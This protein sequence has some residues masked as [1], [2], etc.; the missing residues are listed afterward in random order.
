[1]HNNN[2]YTSK[3]IH[4]LKQIRQA[5]KASNQSMQKEQIYAD[6]PY[7]D[8]INE[9]ISNY[10]EFYTYYTLKLQ[11]AKVTRPALI[12]DIDPDLYISSEDATNLELMLKGKSPYA[13][14]EE[15]GQIELHHI[16]QNYNAPFAE[17]TQ[18]EHIMYGNNKVFHTASEESWRKDKILEK[19]FDKERSEYWRKRASGDYTAISNIDFIDIENKNFVL[20][21]ELQEEINETIEA[22]YNECSVKDLDYL[23]DLAKS[24]SLV[25]RTGFT[26]MSEFIFSTRNKDENMV[27][28]PN[29]KSSQ[30]TFYGF[31][32]NKYEKIQRYKCSWCGKTFTATSL[33]LISNTYFSYMDWIKFIDCIYNGYTLAQT[34]KAC[35]VSQQTVHSNKIKLFYALKIL[36]DQVQLKGNVVVDETYIPLSF[37]G[38]RTKNENFEMPREAHKRGG[39]IHSKGL[40]KDHV[41]IVCAL[42]DEGN[43]VC[44][45]SG[46]GSPKAVKIEK[47]I[48]KHINKENISCIYSDK[49]YAIGTYTKNNELPHKT[50]ISNP[51]KRKIKKLTRDE[52][53]T[54]RNLQKINSY[55]SRLKKF[56]A[57]FGGP[58]TDLLSGYLYLFA[59]KERNK[60]I[61]PIEAYK[62]LLNVMTEPNIYLSTEEITTKGYLPSAYEIENQKEIKFGDVKRDIEIYRRYADGETMAEIGR[63]MDMT[64]QNISRIVAKINKSGL[65]YKT[66]WEIEKEEKQKKAAV[67]NTPQNKAVIRLMFNKRYFRNHLIYDIYVNWA[68]STDNFYSYI[69]YLYK[70]D[71]LSI[72]AI[73]RAIREVKYMNKLKESIRIN[74]TITYKSL[75]EV[76]REIYQ[77]YLQRQKDY[78]FDSQQAHCKILGE[79]YNFTLQNIIRIVNIMSTET[80]TE[81][82]SKKRKL[83]AEEKFNRD[84]AVFV[85]YLNWNGTRHEFCLCAK[86]KYNVSYSYIQQILYFVLSADVKRYDTI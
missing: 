32:E 54:L 45:V 14:D 62:E 27:I 39:E 12:K 53:I 37:K 78:P 43:S 86:D 47:A 82:F 2:D 20:P 70:R 26:T 18:A 79:K 1:M 85:D 66:K 28:C 67:R 57:G 19:N 40:G 5:V 42:D 84:K 49:S 29:C 41:C 30:Y 10:R 15:D 34:A 38:N 44:H 17:L 83:T 77:D 22:L 36:D 68:D 33:S 81:Y 50:V 63:N 76:Y 51:G 73:K 56:I 16:G 46:L 48:G 60:D 6:S 80:E 11:E 71:N 69:Q 3:T 74:D 4:D 65:G 8:I 61:E 25:K 72:S 55:H 31:Q 9:Y 64:R 75:E 52:Y 21:K 58:S 7:S 23:S 59:W 13:Y 35:G 24:Y